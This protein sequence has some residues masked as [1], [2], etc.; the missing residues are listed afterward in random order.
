MQLTAVNPVFWSCL[1]HPLDSCLRMYSR[2]LLHGAPSKSNMAEFLARRPFSVVHVDANWDGYRKV[3]SDRISVIEL[4]FAQSVSFGYVDCDAEQE[5]AREIG[6]VN[7][8]SVV[9][10]S[11]ARLSAVV[12]G[13]KQKVVANIERLMG[14]E[15]LDQTNAFSSG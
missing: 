7:V 1:D 12:I 11:G 5:F 14:G 15:T 10:Y 3:L 8:P 9:Y 2:R 6:I 4:Q 13:V